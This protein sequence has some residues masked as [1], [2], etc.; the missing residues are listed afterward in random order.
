VASKGSAHVL[1]KAAVALSV[2]AMLLAFA[3]RQRTHRIEQIRNELGQLEVGMTMKEVR[4][5]MTIEPSSIEVDRGSRPSD[6]V[7]VWRFSTFPRIEAVQPHIVFDST[8]SRLIDVVVGTRA[9][10]EM[11]PS[12]DE[13]HM[14]LG[15]WLDRNEPTARE[16]LLGLG[17]DDIGQRC[18]GAKLTDGTRL[19]AG[20]VFLGRMDK[21]PEGVHGF[22]F[23]RDEAK[24]ACLWAE[25]LGRTFR[26]PK[27][28][29]RTALEHE[30][31]S[32]DVY[33]Y[34]DV[35][36]GG[37]IVIVWCVPDD[38]LVHQGN[39]LPAPRR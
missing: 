34:G 28:A 37:R 38:W 11:E 20:D 35:Q 6:G 33:T 39:G 17:S 25:N 16:Y 32:R 18:D 1:T 4:E 23:Q 10:P 24:F 12:V 9:R 13:E 19:F 2:L 14:W 27:C 36:P 30:V 26:L 29:D 7:V 15:D 3:V 5:S 22:L 31:I 21:L 8:T